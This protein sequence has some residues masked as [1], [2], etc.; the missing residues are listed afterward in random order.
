MRV[1]L[2]TNAYSALLSGEDNIAD[3]LENSVEILIPAVVIGELNGGFQTGKYFQRNVHELELFLSKPGVFCIDSSKAIAERYGM[4][5][6]E[7][8]EKGTPIPTNDV[9]ISAVAL[10]TGARLLTRDSHFSAIPGIMA[11]PF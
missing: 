11:V 5:I 8:K 3:I 1:V 2:D 10:E 9:W 7:L 4:L 6:K